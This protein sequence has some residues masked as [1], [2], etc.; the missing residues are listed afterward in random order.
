L[1]FKSSH[2][3]VGT[4]VTSSSVDALR[5]LVRLEGDIVKISPRGYHLSNG[6]EYCTVAFKGK[7]G[8]QYSIQ[9]YGKE[10]LE[11]HN[12]ARMIMETPMMMFPQKV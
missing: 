5:E 8:V 10:A 6:V 1:S 3:G 9:A 4:G 11:L 2:L 12:E 7:G